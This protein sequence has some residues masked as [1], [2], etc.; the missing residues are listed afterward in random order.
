MGD[1]DLFPSNWAEDVLVV[2][3]WMPFFTIDMGIV[4]AKYLAKGRG[5]ELG[6]IPIQPPTDTPSIV[7]LKRLV[8]V[9]DQPALAEEV[10][11][12]PNKGSI[13]YSWND[14]IW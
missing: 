12:H 3:V 1:V 13:L 8:D 14:E 10:T 7:H 9:D 2:R 5:D 11:V 4:V 6:L